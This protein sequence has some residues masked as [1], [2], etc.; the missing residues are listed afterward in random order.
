MS[1]LPILLRPL[2]ECLKVKRDHRVI[3]W[4]SCGAASAVATV[5]AYHKYGPSLEVVYCKVIEEHPD[6]LKFIEEF[7]R[8]TGIPVT[9]LVN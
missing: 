6:N 3:S 8:I 5:I 2:P 9:I 7:T 4:F 1:D